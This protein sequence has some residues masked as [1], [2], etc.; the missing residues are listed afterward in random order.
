VLST[1]SSDSNTLSIVGEIL[2][3]ISLS[4]CDHRKAIPATSMIETKSFPQSL[5][6]S[7]FS[8]VSPYIHFSMHDVKGEGFPAEIERLMMG[9]GYSPHTYK[10]RLQA[11]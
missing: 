11:C 1:I 8:H 2:G 3:S 4:N 9:T 7:M 10:F 5:R 6:R